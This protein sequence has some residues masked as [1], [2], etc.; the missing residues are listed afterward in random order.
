MFTIIIREKRATRNAHQ[1][2]ERIEVLVHRR[3]LKRKGT[4]RGQGAGQFLKSTKSL[5]LN[6]DPLTSL[7]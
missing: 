6:L 1:K 3:V 7:P 5:R 2:G 4:V